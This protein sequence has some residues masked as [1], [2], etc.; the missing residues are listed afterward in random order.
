MDIGR[1]TA[2]TC[3][4]GYLELI[5]SCGRRGVLNLLFWGSVGVRGGRGCHDNLRILSIL[6]VRLTKRGVGA[7]LELIR[8][9]GSWGVLNLLFL[10]VRGCPW[11]SV[12]VRGG[13]S[14]TRIFAM[15]HVF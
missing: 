3:C 9:H 4:R 6:A 13:F 12:G 2:Q 11:V 5:R 7:H 14:M 15:V 1:K 10:G 8:L